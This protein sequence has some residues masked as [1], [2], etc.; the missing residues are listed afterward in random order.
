MPQVERTNTEITRQWC[1]APMKLDVY[2]APVGHLEG[3][4][5]YKCAECDRQE[6]KLILPNTRSSGYAR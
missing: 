4:A 1:R 5:I 6:D 2:I 3:M